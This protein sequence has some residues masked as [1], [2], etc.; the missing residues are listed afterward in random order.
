ME[1]PDIGRRPR[2]KD[3]N[4]DLHAIALEV[5]AAQDSG[6]Q[7]EPLS[8][9]FPGFDVPAAYR[10]ADLVH[11]RRLAEGA[12]VAGRK[13]GFTNSGIW[14]KYG[15]EAPI[16]GYVYDETVHRCRA[17][18]AEVTSPVELERFAEPRIEP[19]LVLGLR[20]PPSPDGELADMRDAVEWIALGFEVVQSHFPAWRFAAADTVADGALHG[21]LVVG[22][23]IPLTRIGGDV[24]GALERFE[25]T[26]T[27][28]GRR[29]ATGRGG[30]VLGSALFALQYL[31]SVLD[32]HPSAAALRPGELVT[33]G[34]VA[35]AYPVQA[36]QRWRAE[37]RGIGLPALTV[38]F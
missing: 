19:E 24:A 37:V 34:T 27:C 7:I 1:Q 18:D 6:S 4:V 13:L 5:K 17:A 11:R 38:T 35:D 31:C 22:P 26:L 14:E 28:D 3:P 20:A 32:E 15:V 10:V 2:Q 8:S 30:N 25:L 33:T 23:P 16:W 36:G 21:M 12:T 9:R 29:V